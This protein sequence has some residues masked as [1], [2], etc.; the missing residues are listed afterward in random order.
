MVVPITK[1]RSGD[2]N[3]QLPRYMTPG[4]VGM[5]IAASIART[6]VLEPSGRALIPTGLAIAL[7]ENY[8]AQ[9]RPRSGLALRN[10]LTVLNSPGTID[11]DYRDEIKV[12]LVN[13]GSGIFQIHNG[14]RIA[15]MVICPVTRASWEEVE[16]LDSTERGGG[17]GHTGSRG[18]EP[19]R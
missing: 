12:L 8:E 7:P 4:S 14:D 9:I 1:L 18:T 15:Q 3:V 16:S 5:D 6:E 2:P 11:S 13:L 10:G 19:P 17:F